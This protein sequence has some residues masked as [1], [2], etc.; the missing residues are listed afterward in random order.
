LDI[1]EDSIV[2]SIE[3]QDAITC[4]LDKGFL[5]VK[6]CKENIIEV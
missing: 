2:S 4:T 5:K 3:E 6:I 1:A